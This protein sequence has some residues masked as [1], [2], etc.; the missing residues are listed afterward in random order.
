MK[1][2]NFQKIEIPMI[3]EKRNSFSFRG[4]VF[5]YT[6]PKELAKKT[7]KTFQELNGILFFI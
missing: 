4:E 3:E 6:C 7:E 1:P 2:T 5:E